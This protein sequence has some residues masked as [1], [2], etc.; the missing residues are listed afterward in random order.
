MRSLRSEREDCGRAAGVVYDG[1]VCDVEEQR[2]RGVS[3]A[4]NGSKSPLPEQS[5]TPL[6]FLALYALIYI[7]IVQ[8]IPVPKPSLLMP[9]VS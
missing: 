8:Y 9:L 2:M 6:Q 5:T 3:T 4:A 7:V 1:A